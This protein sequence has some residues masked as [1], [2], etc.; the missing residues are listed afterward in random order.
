M[1]S[2]TQT[3]R[4]LVIGWLY[5]TKMNIYGDRGNVVALEKRAQWRGIDVEVRE[6]GM[7][8]GIPDDVDIFFWGGGQDQ[9]QVSVAKDIA[10]AK[11]EA[12]RAAV[13]NGAAMLAICGGYQLLGHGYQPHEGETLPGV[14]LFDATSVAGPTRF[15][16]NVVIE[17]PEFGSLVGF[18]NHSG[19]THLQGDAVPL[20]RVVVGNG[21]NGSDGTEGVI[22]KNAIGCYLHGSLL[23]KNPQLTDWLLHAGLRHRYGEDMEFA[24]LNDALE[25]AAHTSATMRARNA[26]SS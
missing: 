12:I 8:E 7:G 25:Q 13:D 9:E 22:Y 1:T 14:G 15:I 4:K 23:P 20:G 2:G 21:N 3:P 11:G 24:Q 26:R 18:E 17:S 10:G 5:G 16:G 19:L 6:I